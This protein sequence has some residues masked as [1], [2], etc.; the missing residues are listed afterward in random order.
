[1]TVPPAIAE[2]LKTLLRNNA[3]IEI[4]I[5]D[6]AYQ[7]FPT[8]AALS[9]DAI[10]QL[11]Q[12]IQSW[13]QP[14]A[15]FVALNLAIESEMGVTDTVLQSIYSLRTTSPEIQSWFVDY[16]NVQEQRRAALRP[17]E[18]LLGTD[19]GCNVITLSPL[20]PLDP[21]HLPQVIFID[22]FLDPLDGEANSL[23]LAKDIGDRIT[24]IFAEHPKPFVILMSSKDKLTDVMKSQFRDEARFLGGMFYFIP[25]QDLGPSIT[26]LLRFGVLVRSLND[27]RQ[28]QEFVEA[29]EREIGTTVAKFTER[30]RALSLEDYAYIQKLTLHGEG[31]PLG[32]Y[33]LWLFGTYFAHLLFRSVPRQRRQLDSMHF[34]QIAESDGMPSREFVELYSNVV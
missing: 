5:I 17:L 13:E 7:V 23:Q 19:L 30:V 20:S 14:T 33:L 29:F 8:R 11:V 4:V 25:K 3:I 1:M 31:M 12:R 32:D 26:F 22:Y 27:G 21:A 2:A 28:I 18:G 15:E 24:T 10:A 16:D 6:D 34:E 9:G